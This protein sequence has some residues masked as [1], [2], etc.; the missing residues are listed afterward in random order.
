[1][2]ITFGDGIG[3]DP[4]TEVIVACLSQMLLG[5]TEDE[6]RYGGIPVTILYDNAK[7]HS[8][9]A[10]R[11]G[12]QDFGIISRPIP[13]ASPWLQGKVEAFVDTFTT[14]FLVGKPGYTGGAPDRY[15]RDTGR[16]GPLLNKAQFVALA[17]AW[18]HDYNFTRPHSALGGLTP[19]QQWNLGKNALEFIDE[20]EAALHFLGDPKPRT[21]DSYGVRFDKIDFTDPVL[22]Y[23]IGEDVLIRYL[24]SLREFVHVHTLSGEF[25]CKAEPHDR[26]SVE[27]R[28]EM[29]RYSQSVDRF[30]VTVEKTARDKAQ[31]RAVEELQRLGFAGVEAQLVDLDAP[32]AV[33]DPTEL[34]ISSD[35]ASTADRLGRLEA[36]LKPPTERKDPER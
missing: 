29:H 7:A 6:V 16:K 5:F 26:L 15:G 34:F 4:N 12:C 33:E 30:T 36:A 10:V 28:A 18:A 8:A 31:R 25:L 14:E 27:A 17:G 3:G 19:A 20:D 23:H 9:E 21:V 1:M 13:P 24:P 32:Q 2:A 22:N 11:N 35:E